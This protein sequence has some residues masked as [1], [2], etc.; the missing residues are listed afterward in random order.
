MEK[1]KKVAVV[2]PVDTHDNHDHDSHKKPATKPKNSVDDKGKVVT[3]ANWYTWK[4]PAR[5]PD[6]DVDSVYKQCGSLIPPKANWWG[7]EGDEGEER[8]QRAGGRRLPLVPIAHREDLGCLAELYGLKTGAEL[9]VQAGLFEG[10]PG[11][12]EKLRE[13]HSRRFVAPA[14]ALRRHRQR[15]QQ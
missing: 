15:G 1:P 14:G 2:P 13:V 10:H 8:R 4:Y 12:L 3:D 6:A 9:G 7:D 11:A 5:A